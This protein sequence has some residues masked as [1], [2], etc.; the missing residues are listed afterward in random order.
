MDLLEVQFAPTGKS[1]FVRPGTTL[2]AASQLAGLDLA[3]GCTR[4]M[5]GTDVVRIDAGGEHLAA[6]GATELGTLLRMGLGADHRLACSATVASGRV[7]VMV[8][9]F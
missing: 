6:P 7:V 4:G 3:T 5:C 9:D 8:G 1:V 2:L